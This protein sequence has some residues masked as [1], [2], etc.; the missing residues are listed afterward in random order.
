VTLE[1]RVSLAVGGVR[2]LDPLPYLEMLGLV[3]DVV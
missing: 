2:L 3:S 1:R